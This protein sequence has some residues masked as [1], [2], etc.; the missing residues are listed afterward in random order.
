MSAEVKREI[1]LEIAYV[2][3]VDI[4]GYSRYSIDQQRRLLELLNEIV[5]RLIIFVRRRRVG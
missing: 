5:A 4:V 3:F 1:E 2:L